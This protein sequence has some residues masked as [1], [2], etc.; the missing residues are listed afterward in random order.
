MGFQMNKKKSVYKR[1]LKNNFNKVQMTRE[2][3]IERYVD[4][5]V[6]DMD[7]KTM[8]MCLCDFLYEE[9]KHESDDE[10]DERYNEYFEE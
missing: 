9:L 6:Q 7:M 8:Y 1:F 2:E 4:A 10:V 3:K 5:V